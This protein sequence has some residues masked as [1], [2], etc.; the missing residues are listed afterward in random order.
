MNIGSAGEREKKEY[1]RANLQAI[2]T[3]PEK[4]V[5]QQ[6][7]KNADETL[8]RIVTAPL[9]EELHPTPV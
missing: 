9:G 8:G 1:A 7:Q 4:N 2:L 3:K 5:E 6:Q